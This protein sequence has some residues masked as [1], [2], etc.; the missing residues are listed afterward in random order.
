MSRI[1]WIFAMLCIAVMT[2]WSPSAQAGTIV[3]EDDIS[4]LEPMTS[5][6]EKAI[7]SIEKRPFQKEGRGEISIGVSAIASD[8]FLVYMPVTIRGG[9]HFKEWVSLEVTAS[10]MGCFSD[11][12]GDNQTRAAGQRC[13]RFLT[14]TYDH[15][16][17]PGSDKTQLR[18]ITI[19]EY[20]VARFSLT[21][22]FSV[23][24]GKFAI[25][26]A[27]I[28][29][30]DINLAAGLG[31]KIV[32]MPSKTP[33]GSIEYGASVEGSLG[34]GVRF[35]FLDFVGIRLDFREYLFGKQNDKGLGT[36]SEFALSVSFL[37]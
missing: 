15:L 1:S 2:A 25:A 20:D 22:V 24:M 33:G 18:G 10:Y 35:V 21:P 13:M 4:T 31:A 29:H 30:F 16:T 14:P 17:G 37:L 8:I 9:Y 34:L 6:Q 7:V 32:E 27:G 12:T 28:A 11:D 26:G 5:A 23:F 19:E 3:L 36:S